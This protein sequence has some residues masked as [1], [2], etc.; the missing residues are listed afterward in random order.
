MKVGI[1]IKLRGVLTHVYNMIN[2]I[3]IHA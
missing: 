3:S 2:M 1:G